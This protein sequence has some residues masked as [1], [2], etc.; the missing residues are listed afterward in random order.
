MSGIKVEENA[1]EKKFTDKNSL[2]QRVGSD[3]DKLKSEEQ[4]KNEIRK[5][6]SEMLQILPEPLLIDLDGLEEKDK[7]WLQP[8]QDISDYFNYGFDETTFKSYQQTVR[9]KFSTI[10]KEKLIEEIEKKNL[11]LDHTDINFYLPH[12]AGG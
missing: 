11:D 9:E 4:K 3:P 8:G 12:E 6:I 1:P 7:P 10:D 2:R 5:K